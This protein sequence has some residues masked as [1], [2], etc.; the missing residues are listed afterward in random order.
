MKLQFRD[1]PGR[2]FLLR[3]EYPS[4]MSYKQSRAKCYAPAKTQEEIRRAAGTKRRVMVVNRPVEHERGLAAQADGLVKDF[5]K[6]VAEGLRRH[7]RAFTGYGDCADIGVIYNYLTPDS[8]QT[9]RLGDGQA[10]Y[11][12]N[13]FD[14]KKGAELWAPAF[15]P[16]MLA[17]H[18]IRGGE[19]SL[20]EDVREDASRLDESDVPLPEFDA[21]D[22]YEDDYE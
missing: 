1:H 18:L 3:P 12:L 22:V 9:V 2:T 17:A 6:R 5:T 4:E 19:D 15:K 21:E 7:A 11:S 14:A 10:Y 20:N 16:P 8:A 13:T